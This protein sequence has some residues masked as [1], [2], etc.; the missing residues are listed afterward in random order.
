VKQGFYL[1]I[2]P[3]ARIRSTLDTS[4]FNFHVVEPHRGLTTKQ[5]RAIA[6][7]QRDRASANVAATL[8][9]LREALT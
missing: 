1:D 7:M 4:E 3:R 5:L 6:A 9:A 8:R 2:T